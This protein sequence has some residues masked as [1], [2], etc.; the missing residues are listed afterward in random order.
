MQELCLR[1]EFGYEEAK[2]IIKGYFTSSGKKYFDC[3]GVR[4]L[5]HVCKQK[6]ING[7]MQERRN[8][9]ANTLEL[10]LSSTNPSI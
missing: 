8:S 1:L 2:F 4:N 6:H 7:L 3:P 5:K 10:R 9:I